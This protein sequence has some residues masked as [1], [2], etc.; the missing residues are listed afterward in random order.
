MGVDYYNM[1]KVSRNA[2]DE[3]LKKAYRRL[4][5]RWHPDK[6]PNN[7]KEAESKFK[8]ISQAYD[9]LS[10]PQKRQIY[11]LYGADALLSGDIP[12]NYS[13]TAPPPAPPS[14]SGSSNR[15]YHHSQQEQHHPTANAATPPPP[16][17]PAS[18]SSSRNQNSTYQ[19][20]DPDE[21][22]NEFF[23]GP[24]GNKTK[25]SKKAPVLENKL[26]CKLEDL[27]LG[28]KRKVKI[29]KSV[30]DESGKP[31]IKEEVLTIDIT[32]GWKKGTKITFPEKG[33]QA[34][35]GV[36][37]GDLTFVIDER[38]HALYKRDGNDL[39]VNQRISLLE[40]LTGKTLSF[41]SLDGRNLQYQVTD[42]VKPG[43]E[44]VIPN[45]GM[46][47]SR[48]PGKKGNLRVKFDVKFPA[49]LT[50][51]QKSSLKRVLAG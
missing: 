38:P 29:S 39:L 5:M 43:Y 41:T 30:L 24:D 19:P 34:S 14:S 45:E 20:R 51:E 23:G 11:D 22:Y 33:H 32:P 2:S 28:A 8:Q 49:I 47:I 25:S 37:P 21:I 10:D 18:S 13:T 16:P 17:M 15:Y 7:K 12:E 1:L 9:V 6:N 3:N 50:P 40:A 26:P 48:E 35:R 44:M 36:A 4:A 27:Y 42:I 46:P 31:V